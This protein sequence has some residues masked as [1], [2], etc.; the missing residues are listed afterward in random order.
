MDENHHKIHLNI[1][2][3][4]DNQTKKATKEDNSKK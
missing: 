2:K 1:G 3:K 4:K